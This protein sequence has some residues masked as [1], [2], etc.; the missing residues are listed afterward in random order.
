MD[1]HT[2]VNLTNSGV[3]FIKIRSL[4]SNIRE[5]ADFQQCYNP[6]EDALNGRRQDS[7]VPCTCSG[8]FCDTFRG[9][10]IISHVNLSSCELET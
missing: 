5:Q 8:H 4:T 10:I 7:G 1:L 3:I 2:Q 9:L 6:K